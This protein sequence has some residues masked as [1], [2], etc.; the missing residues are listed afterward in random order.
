V[1]ACAISCR[2]VAD[3]VLGIQ[4]DEVSGKGDR[5]LA[6]PAAAEATAGVV[7]TEGPAGEVVLLK[8]GNGK[9]PCVVE[10]Q[11][12]ASARKV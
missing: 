11:T 2:G 9:R 6:V 12:F 5:P 7:E 1:R 10:V 4:E 8:Q 3:L